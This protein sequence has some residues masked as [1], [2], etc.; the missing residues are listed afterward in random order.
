MGNLTMANI[1][2]KASA[3]SAAASKGW[4]GA[5]DHIFYVISTMPTTNMRIFV[6][7]YIAVR[8]TEAYIRSATWVP[9]LEWLGFILAMAGVDT[10]QWFAKRKTTFNP[11]DT[12][13][14]PLV[15]PVV[16]VT[17]PAQQSQ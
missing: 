5:I 4:K 7:M 12:T 14:S 13:T 6:T 1:S 10:L 16:E 8:T 3:A 11:A 15:P 17:P 2:E 9:A